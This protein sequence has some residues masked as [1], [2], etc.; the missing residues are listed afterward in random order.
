MM[1]CNRCWRAAESATAASAGAAD[2]RPC[3]PSRGRRPGPP[4]IVLPVNQAHTRAHTAMQADKGEGK[5]DRQLDNGG[6]EQGRTT[7]C[8]ASWFCAATATASAHTLSRRTQKQGT[9]THTPVPRDTNTQR[10]SNNGHGSTFIPAAVQP[11]PPR[12]RQRPHAASPQPNLRQTT[13]HQ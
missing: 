4:D 2:G 6:G 9:R 5:G 3:R 12:S 13:G 10:Y 7:A 1:A 8:L 11:V